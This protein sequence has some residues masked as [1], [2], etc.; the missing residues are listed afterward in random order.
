MA[1]ATSEMTL[2]LPLWHVTN[3]G[4]SPSLERHTE[5]TEFD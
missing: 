5:E 4:D 3:L 2:P 1:V